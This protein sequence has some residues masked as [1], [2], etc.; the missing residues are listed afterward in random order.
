[1]LRNKIRNGIV[2]LLASCLILSGAIKRA[3]RKAFSGNYITG[4]YFHNPNRKLFLNCIH[5]LKKNH[6]VFIN[7]EQLQNMLQGREMVPPGAIWI[8]FDDG[9][10]ENLRNVI[11]VIN[12][13]KVPITLFIPSGIIENSGVFWWSYTRQF[14]SYLP[15]PYRVN[16]LA[17]L[18]VPEKVRKVVMEKFLSQVPSSLE[19]EAITV[20]ELQ[21]L[22]RNPLVTIGAHTV[23]HVVIPNCEDREREYEIQESQKH[24]ENWLGKEIKYFAYP[25]GRFAN[26]E[27]ALLQKYQFTLAATTANS[28]ITLQNDPYYIPRFTVFDA[29]TYPEAICSMVGVWRP[30]MDN[31]KKLIQ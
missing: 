12:E 27:G 21:E 13:Y 9:W 14:S 29:A 23:N 22:G 3:K 8:S 20:T 11:P 18:E 4:L 16:R 24:L 15:E 6:Y 7:A 28:F 10:R 25:N 2:S 31:L 19:R 30:F 26:N 1:M 5:W 17:L